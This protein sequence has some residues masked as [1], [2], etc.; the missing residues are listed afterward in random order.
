MRLS[1]CS[2]CAAG[3]GAGLDGLTGLF[4]PQELSGLEKTGSGIR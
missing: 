4:L 1:P 3:A 2:G